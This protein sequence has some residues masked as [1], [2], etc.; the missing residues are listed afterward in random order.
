MQ[1]EKF[2]NKAFIS[3][4][5]GA[6]F[7]TLGLINLLFFCEDY[8][9]V[10]SVEIVLCQTKGAFTLNTALTGN[11]IGYSFFCIL[12]GYFVLNAANFF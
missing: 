3:V 8:T 2:C 6:V 12:V 4:R 5:D 11:K 7:L 10:M 1:E 9:Y